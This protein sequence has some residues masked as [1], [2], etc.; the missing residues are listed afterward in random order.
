VYLGGVLAGS[1]QAEHERQVREAAEEDRREARAAQAAQAR[2]AE[3]AAAEQ[4]ALEQLVQSLR[5]ELED[6][7]L[8]L[9]WCDCAWRVHLSVGSDPSESS[10]PGVGARGA[11]P[12]PPV[13][14]RRGARGGCARVSETVVV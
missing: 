6:G 1:M 14:R 9:Q 2:Q 3:E 12:A 13:R 7:R 4:R 8:R 11:G 10:V 5:A